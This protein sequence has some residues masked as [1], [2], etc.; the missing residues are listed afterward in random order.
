LSLIARRADLVW[1][2]RE[3]IL[4]ARAEHGAP[5]LS[6]ADVKAVLD[7]IR[8]ERAEQLVATTRRRKK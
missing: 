4:A 2:N 7:Q 5:H 6:N 3:V 8:D 1:H